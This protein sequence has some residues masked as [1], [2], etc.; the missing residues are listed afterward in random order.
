M[1]SFEEMIEDEEK[2]RVSEGTLYLVTTPIGNLS[3]LSARAIKILRGVDLIAAEDTRNA[4]KLLSIL[5]IHGKELISYYEHNKRARGEV[6]A[7]RLIEGASVALITDAGTP[8]ISDPGEDLVRLCAERDIPV[9]AVPGPCA[10]INALSLSALA[11]GR[12]AFEGF[13][14]TNTGERKKRLAEIL[15][16]KRTMIFYEAPHKLRATLSDLYATFGN[17]HIALCREMTKRNE[18]IIRTTLEKAIAYYEIN[19]PRGEYVLIL[20]G[21]D[22]LPEEMKQKEE[23]WFSSLSHEEHVAAYEKKG[24]SR[25]DAIK[26]AAKDLGVSKSTLYR[27]LQ[28]N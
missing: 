5:D 2:N 22:A 6:I 18:E 26:A 24:L 17:R 15:H 10:A 12:F 4:Q 8:A 28:K 13:L 27:E 20:E 7:A 19:A 9:T 1:P 3:D 14:S 25:M 21:E 16:E 23:S 11:T